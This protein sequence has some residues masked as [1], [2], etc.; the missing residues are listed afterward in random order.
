MW[1]KTSQSK[2]QQM[3]FNDPDWITEIQAAGGQLVFSFT[4]AVISFQPL[5]IMVVSLCFM[6]LTSVKMALVSKQPVET[7]SSAVLRTNGIDQSQMGAELT[8]TQRWTWSQ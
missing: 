8:K 3:C 7:D 1:G 4:A 2:H 6:L 5:A